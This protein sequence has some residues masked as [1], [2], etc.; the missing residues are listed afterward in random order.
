MQHC[1]N[2]LISLTHTHIHNPHT[3]VN[4]T[5]TATATHTQSY[6]VTQSNKPTAPVFDSSAIELNFG[7]REKWVGLG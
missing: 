4:H 7:P 1:G 2:K 3:T 6:T 5:H